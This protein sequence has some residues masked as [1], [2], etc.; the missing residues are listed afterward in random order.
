MNDELRNESGETSK[1]RPRQGPVSLS[2]GRVFGMLAAVVLLLT[3]LAFLGN[4]AWWLD[5]LNQGRMQ[6]LTIALVL[7]VILLLTRAWSWLAI[8]VAAAAINAWF[9]APWFWGAPES[10]P[11]DADRDLRLMVLNV[12]G[13][14][15]DFEPVLELLRRDRPDLVVLNEV[16][17]AWLEQIRDV[18]AGYEIYDTPTQGKFGVLLLSRLPVESVEVETFTG[19][20]SP[21]IVARLDMGGQ[22]AVLIAT[23]PPAPLDSKTWENR[24]EHLQELAQYVGGRAEPVLVAGDLNITMWSPHFDELVEQADLSDTRDGFGLHPTFPASRWG[25]DLPWPL[26]VPLDHVLATEEWTTLSCRAGPNVGSDHLPLIVDV[27]LR[28]RD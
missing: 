13:P 7:V 24:N 22:P 17:P 16:D 12:R 8:A 3:L 28:K 27:A 19:R 18:S 9:V 11:A 6:Y 5:V 14:S 1:G 15:E 23:H 10:A 20:W 26:R 21:S 25:L 2:V 4:S